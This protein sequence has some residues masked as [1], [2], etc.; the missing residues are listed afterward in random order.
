MPGRALETAVTEPG[1]GSPVVDSPCASGCG[2]ESASGLYAQKLAG[3]VALSKDLDLLGSERLNHE[4]INPELKPS[5]VERRSQSPRRSAPDV[6]SSTAASS[7]DACG[8][9]HADE[10]QGLD[11]RSEALPALINLLSETTPMEMDQEHRPE[12]PQSIM[13]IT[14]PAV[15]ETVIEPTLSGC[16]DNAAYAAPPTVPATTALVPNPYHYYQPPPHAPHAGTGWEGQQ[17]MTPPGYY[18]HHPAAADAYALMACAP[19]ATTDQ[20]IATATALVPAGASI[21]YA[22]QIEPV[23]SY[24]GKRVRPVGGCDKCEVSRG[25][26]ATVREHFCT[27]GGMGRARDVSRKRACQLR[28][29]AISSAIDGVAL[30][31]QYEAECGVKLTNKKQK[32]EA[33]MRNVYGVERLGKAPHH[34]VTLYS[35]PHRIGCH[36]GVAPGG[37]VRLTLRPPVGAFDPEAFV[38]V[39]KEGKV[40]TAGRWGAPSMKNMFGGFALVDLEVAPV[41]LALPAPTSGA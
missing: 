41:P 40:E 18:H 5:S 34:K 22:P 37:Y 39:D 35:Q 23:D 14:E 7:A 10:Q 38:A 19:A 3:R 12:T 24:L 26:D 31:E 9:G 1:E 30:L 8:R 4:A 25:P 20:I 11:V 13:A 6:S 29:H 17:H 32:F 2:M 16:K 33:F 28:A 21:R 27:D 15:Y 36:L